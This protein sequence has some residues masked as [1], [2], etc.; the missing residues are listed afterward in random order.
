MMG[1][2]CTGSW[3]Q[4]S[5]VPLVV[6]AAVLTSGCVTRPKWEAILPK[7]SPKVITKVY[8]ERG[9]RTN[10]SHRGQRYEILGLGPDPASDLA[11]QDPDKKQDK[12]PGGPQDPQEQRQREAILRTRFG[13]T[14]I[15]NGELIT[16]RY[17][18]GGETGA[19]FLNLLLKPGATFDPIKGPFPTNQLFGG[20]EGDR[21]SVLGMRLNA[22]L[23]YYFPEI[24]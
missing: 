2:L 21:E 7:R 11:G 20:K 17:F 4:R 18:L 9:Q 12:K 19:V 6:L 10:G 22:V 8:D 24:F 13:A 15:I 16:K 14:V 3:M 5:T 23:T 1:K